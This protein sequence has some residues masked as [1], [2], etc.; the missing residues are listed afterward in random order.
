[1]KVSR[2]AILL[3]LLASAEPDRA[4]GGDITLSFPL[5]GGNPYTA[6]IITV[7]DHSAATFYD[8]SATTVQAYTGEVGRDRC[9]PSGQPCGFYNLVFTARNDADSRTFVVNGSYDGITAGYVGTSADCTALGFSPSCLERK[10]ILNYRGHPGHDYAG[11][12]GIT[13]IVA[14]RSGKVFLPRKDDRVNGNNKKNSPWC[15]WHAF[16]IDHG[17]GWTTWYLHNQA[18]IHRL[19]NRIPANYCDSTPTGDIPLGDVGDQEVI[20]W[21]GDVGVEGSPHLHFEVRRNGLIVDPYGWE[22]VGSDPI[23]LNPLGAPQMSPL[24]GTVSPGVATVLLTPSADGFNATITGQN[25]ESGA[26]VT[27]WDKQAQYFFGKYVPAPASVT[28]T[29]IIVDLAGIADPTKYVLKVK[30]PSGP[31]SRGVA[32][33]V[34][35]P[36]LTSVPLTLLGQP[37]DGGGAFASFAEFYG[38]NNAGDVAFQAGVDLSGNCTPQNIFGC[39]PGDFRTFKMTDSQPSLVTVPGIT[40]VGR[41]LMNDAGDMAVARLADASDVNF[42]SGTTMGIFLFPTGA[43]QPIQIAAIGQATPIGGTYL[44]L[45]GPQALSKDGDVAFWAEILDPVQ[46]V[47][48][49]CWYFIYSRGSGAVTKVLA[50][51]D[52]TPVGGSFDLSLGI[53]GGFTDDGDVV[54]DAAV[55]G[56]PTNWG[57]FVARRPAEIGASSWATQKIVAVGDPAPSAIGGTLGRP[58]LYRGR[59]VAGRRI[60][61]DAAINGGSAAE[62]II[63]KDDVLAGGLG[64]LHVVAAVGQ[65]TGTDVGGRFRSFGN[66]SAFIPQIRRDGAVLFAA[67][68]S[69]A[70]VGGQETDQGIFLWTGREM[71]KVAVDGDRLA[72]GRILRGPGNAILN[73]VGQVM[74]FVAKIE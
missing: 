25:F 8:K 49:C 43:T 64:D 9:G 41:V 4:L 35:G 17:G 60:V 58:L 28:S 65:S 10:K 18:L 16:Y 45:D 24:W 62:A 56:V 73:D 63:S 42:G 51:G 61:F 72:T 39:T 6:R 23:A 38:L 66:L 54:F 20:G 29:Q 2:V 37:A 47:G 5:E 69:G 74:Y 67:L 19:A 33:S 71:R 21:V 31:R 15:G 27:L 55:S 12:A 3:L 1:M 70:S 50:S 34:A 13:R 11:T 14:A 32:L 48:L 68:L 53:V 30:N 26:V 40:R 7:V 46:R 36:G 52:P 22:W 57:V 59:P 44:E